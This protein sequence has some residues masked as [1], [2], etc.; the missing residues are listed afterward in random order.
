[1]GF[2]FGSMIALKVGP[3]MSLA[4]T[5]NIGNG[6]QAKVDNWNMDLQSKPTI[7]I[8]SCFLSPSLLASSP[9]IVD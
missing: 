1:M 2:Y 6:T 9:L 8:L 3:I 5:T 4:A 7:G